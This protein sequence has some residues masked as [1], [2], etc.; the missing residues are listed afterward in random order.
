M[1]KNERIDNIYS[2][3]A[4]KKGTEILLSNKVEFHTRAFRENKGGC[5]NFDKIVTHEPF[6]IWQTTEQCNSL[7]H[8]W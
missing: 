4:D 3:N 5:F 1:V 6:L 7:C 2:K 8:G